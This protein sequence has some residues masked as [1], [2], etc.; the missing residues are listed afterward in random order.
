MPSTWESPSGHSRC[1]GRAP[2][3]TTRAAAVEGLIEPIR[4]PSLSQLLLLGLIWGVGMV[5]IKVALKDLPPLTLAAIRSGTAGVALGGYAWLAGEHLR[6]PLRGG[7]L[8]PLTAFTATYAANI[9]LLHLGMVM[10][11]AG[12]ATVLFFTQPVWV[13]FLSPWVL[14]EE[15]LTGGRVLGI[16]L[17]FSGFV[18]VFL[19]EVGGEQPIVVGDLLVTAGAV[20]WAFTTL[21]LR[22]TMAFV[23]P[24]TATFWQMAGATPILLALGLGLEGPLAYRLSPAT[25]MALAYL[26][27]GHIAFGFV[28]WG[29]LI[30]RHG[31]AAVSSF[32]FL[33]PLFS[34]LI[35]F[36]FLGEVP[37]GPLLVGAALIAAGIVLT[38][39]TP[40]A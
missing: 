7:V 10:T 26:A 38:S 32:L 4:L 40:V 22:R 13:T 16:V 23:S 31:P 37:T 2:N 34:V 36:V 8:L 12:R 30:R 17:A 25:A 35:G 29:A 6:L 24:T 33:V 14:H 18:V 5:A 39:R 9:A 3:V 21:S 20:C 27:V 11:S 19:P 15:R 1:A 28:L